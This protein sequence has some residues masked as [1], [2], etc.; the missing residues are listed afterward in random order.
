MSTALNTLFEAIARDELNVPTLATH[1]RDALDFHS[2]GVVSLKRALKRA[3]IA[4]CDATAKQ[5]I[6]SLTVSKGE[7]L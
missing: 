7:R 4:G 6:A 5:F 1:G 2:V 3:Y